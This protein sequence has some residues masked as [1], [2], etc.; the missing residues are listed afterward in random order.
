MSKRRF[1]SEQ[2]NGLLGNRNV[3]KC[4]DRA[5]T[6]ARDFKVRAVKQYIEEGQPAKEIFRT[7]GF[8]LEVIGKDTPKECLGDWRRIFKTKGISGL[9]TETRGRG[10][11]RPRVKGLI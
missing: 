8:D 1:T 2:V 4:S 7:A 3:A 10:G 6:Y 5:I 9:K 11:G